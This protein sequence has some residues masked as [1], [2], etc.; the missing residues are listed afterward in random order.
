MIDL[1][2]N[3]IR[4]QSNITSHDD[5]MLIQH[6]R[7]NK[8]IK[9]LPRFDNKQEISQKGSLISPM[10]GKVIEISVKAGDTVK[11]GQKLLV[12]EAMKMNHSIN[13]DQDGIVQEIY[14]NEGDQLESGTSLLLV[15]SDD[16]E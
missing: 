13:S 12:M 7:G 16:S 8:L 6:S 5:L 2:F 14:V 9:V 4:H 10:P 15:I 1:E 11:R 3:K